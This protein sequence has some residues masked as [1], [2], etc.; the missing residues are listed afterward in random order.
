MQRGIIRHYFRRALVTEGVLT[1]KLGVPILIKQR[2]AVEPL[3][4]GLPVIGRFS[5]EPATIPGNQDYHR[6]RRD[7]D[8][9][10]SHFHTCPLSLLPSDLSRPLKSQLSVAAE[11]TKL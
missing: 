6:D 10:F 3:R 11:V 7:D 5:R 4:Y 1:G 8:P 9:C 2:H